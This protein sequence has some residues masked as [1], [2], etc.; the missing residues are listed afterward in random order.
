MRTQAIFTKALLLSTI[1]ILCSFGN[2]SPDWGF[3]GHKRINRMAVFTLP[4]EMIPFFKKNIEFITEHAVDPDK[5]RYATKHEGVRHYIDI[6]HWGENPL[7]EVPKYLSEAVMKYG[8]MILFT[9][10]GD[11][12][13]LFKYEKPKKN[14]EEKKEEKEGKKGKV[15]NKKDESQLIDVLSEGLEKKTP[16]ST[17]RDGFVVVKKD[18]KAIFG[19]DSMVIELKALS[20]FYNEYVANMYFDDEWKVDAEII[21]GFLGEYGALEK[22][23]GGQIVDHFSGYG[24]LPYHL[25]KM[26]ENLTRAF[27]S[28]NSGRILRMAAEIGHYIG[29][30]HVPLH[31]TENYNGQMTGQDGIHGFWESRLPEMF[32]DDSYN[33]WVGKASY[34]ENPRNFH[35]DVVAESHSYVDTI[36]SLEKELSITFPRDKQY[37]YEMRLERTVRVQC[38]AYATEFHNRLDGMVEKRMTDAVKAIGDV[39]FS[40]WVDAGQ[41]DLMKQDEYIIS[42]EEKKQMEEE[43]KLFKA[44]TIKG[45]NHSN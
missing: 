30:A 8:E 28:G 11:T 39:W 16:Y 27:E 32:A 24:I 41:P 44:G 5:R 25:I 43:E 35:W 22:F 15:K 10:K 33:F 4:P 31:T 17:F 42:E 14:E 34:I 6:D 26:Q 3:F 18:A 40:A 23:T 9:E 7:E 38:T 45:R 36:L 12:L 13:T 1:F 21:N 2:S 29:D 37:C 20:D 19:K